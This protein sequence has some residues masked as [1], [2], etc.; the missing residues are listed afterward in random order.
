MYKKKI[1]QMANEKMEDR[2][3]TIDGGHKNDDQ[4]KKT[5]KRWKGFIVA[6]R[7]RKTTMAMTTMTTHPKARENK[8][9]RI[10]YIYSF[11]Y[12]VYAVN[13]SKSFKMIIGTEC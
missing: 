4:K 8:I 11:I 6:K 5:M 9:R 13:K 1:K 10:E 3:P 7:E 2:K 12:L